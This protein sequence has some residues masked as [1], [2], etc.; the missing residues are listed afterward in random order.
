MAS[1]EMRRA[2]RRKKCSRYTYEGGRQIHRDVIADETA[3][4]L[5][6]GCR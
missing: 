5:N 1:K 2:A 4:L 3:K 6:K